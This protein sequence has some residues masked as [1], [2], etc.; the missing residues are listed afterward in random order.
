MARIA[1][2]LVSL[3]TL[4]RLFGAAKFGA[5]T[6]KNRASASPATAVP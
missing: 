4:R 6:T 3:S 2:K 5:K 1:R